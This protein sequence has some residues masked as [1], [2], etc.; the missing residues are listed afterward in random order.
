MKSNF[1]TQVTARVALWGFILATEIIIAHAMKEWRHV[2]GHDEIS[3]AATC[4]GF[5]ASLCLGKSNLVKTFQ[6]LCL[7][8]VFVQCLGWFAY[9]HQHSMVY[10][11]TLNY[12]IVALK[13]IRLLWPFQIPEAKMLVDWPAIGPFSFFQA[14]RHRQ[15]GTVV[16]NAPGTDKIAYAAILLTFP[17]IY[18]SREMGARMPLSLFAFL[19]A[20]LVVRYFSSFLSYLDQRQFTED[21]AKA[22]VLDA[23]KLKNAELE[24]QNLALERARAEAEQARAEAERAKANEESIS[25]ALRDAAHD[26]RQSISLIGFAGHD[27]V[28]A[29]SLPERQEALRVFYDA[30]HKVTQAIEQ[31]MYY[32]KL[33]TGQATPRLEA[34]EMCST[35]FALCNQW[36]A[37]GLEQGVE[38]LKI[39]PWKE[40]VQR[41]AACDPMLIH[42]VLQ[43][44]LLNAIA[45]AGCDRIVCCVR[46]RPHHYL[47]QIRDCGKG[48]EEGAGPDERANFAAFA[49][50][51]YEGGAKRGDGH[52]LGINI[53]RQLC[54]VAQIEVGLRSRP[55]QGTCFSLWLPKA[56]A[57]LIADTGREHAARAKARDEALAVWRAHNG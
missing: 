37:A 28:K 14:K 55:G 19:G 42:H 27:I 40:G 17:L 32:A 50:R 34:L 39:C 46:T 6:D 16:L 33:T 52:G 8:D 44:L 56:D 9:H 11:L 12:S 4:I 41:Y 13:F 35:L 20:I 22:A 43:N 3:I 5:F 23:T 26:L 51:V 30:N 31:I 24:R 57:A 45:H 53:V 10:Y 36:R 38:L 21:E 47:V 25:R 48:I 49:R 15:A 2:L 1:S 29:A 7:Y 18:L 54:A